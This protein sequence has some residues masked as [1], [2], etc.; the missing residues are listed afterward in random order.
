MP[1]TD[2]K[3]FESKYKIF[4]DGSKGKHRENRIWEREIRGKHGCIYPYGYDGTLASTITSKRLLKR[5]EDVC[6]R[7]IQEGDWEITFIFKPEDI[8]KVAKV[9]RARRKRK[10][11]PEMKKKLIERLKLGKVLKKEEIIPEKNGI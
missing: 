10:I 3:N 9:I 6:L 8:D 11:T 5:L 4:L 7:I 1:V 2:L